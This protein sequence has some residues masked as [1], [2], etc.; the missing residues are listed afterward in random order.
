[1]RST[2]KTMLAKAV[3]AECRTTF[4][5]VSASTLGSKVCAAHLRL[6][7]CMFLGQ[8]YTEQSLKRCTC[9]SLSDAATSRKIVRGDA[10]TRRKTVYMYGDTVSIGTASKHIFGIPLT[11]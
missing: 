8:R 9:F 11:L 1:M 5:N 2:G 3:A 4:F 7:C 6:R 10:A